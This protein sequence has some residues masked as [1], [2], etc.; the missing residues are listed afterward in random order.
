MTEE[1]ADLV[2]SMTEDAEMV[3][4]DLVNNC[5]PITYL[6]KSLR[7]FFF[8]LKSREIMKAISRT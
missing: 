5:T 4:V 3:D 8:I 6:K 2:A 1:N 7:R